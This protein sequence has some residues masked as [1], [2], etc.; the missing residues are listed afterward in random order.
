MKGIITTKDL[1]K[2][3]IEAKFSSYQNKDAE[4]VSPKEIYEISGKGLRLGFMDF[5]AK[6]KYYSKFSKKRLSSCG[7]SLEH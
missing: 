2:K 1:T 3:E 4:Q 5:G 6:A 7:I